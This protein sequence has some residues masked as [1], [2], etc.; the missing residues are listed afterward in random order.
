MFFFCYQSQHIPFTRDFVYKNAFNT[1][2]LDAISIIVIL[3]SKMHII[4]DNNLHSKDVPIKLS[5]KGCPLMLE[6]YQAVKKHSLLP[7][8]V[9]VL[10]GMN[11]CVFAVP[12][13]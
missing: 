12:L 10:G 1:V 6:N 13:D 5:L 11:N 7:V 4:H 2:R 3:K 9:Y 8:Y